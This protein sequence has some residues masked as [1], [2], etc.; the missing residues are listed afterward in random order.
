MADPLTLPTVVSAPAR[1]REGPFGLAAGGRAAYNAGVLRP[2]RQP[3]SRRA[4]KSLRVVSGREVAAL[5][6]SGRRAGDRRLT[7]LA[8]PRPAA[9]D[10]PARVGVAVSARH[11]KAVRRNRVKR[12]CREA[13][14]QIREEL[15]C[16]WDFMMIPRPGARL[17]VADLQASL[18]SLAGRVTRGGEDRRT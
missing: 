5:F 10:A 1:S 2:E 12:L 18:R 7:L 13:F 17:T 8:A 15:P 16:G 11:G 4:P 9:S 3:V 6:E 14:R